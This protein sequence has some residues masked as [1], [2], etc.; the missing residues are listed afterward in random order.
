[1]QKAFRIRNQRNLL[2]RE[3]FHQPEMGRPLGIT[4]KAT[5]VADQAIITP[6]GN[7]LNDD[8]T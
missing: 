3:G 2:F 5:T 7:L 6:S 8:L 1:M 4:I